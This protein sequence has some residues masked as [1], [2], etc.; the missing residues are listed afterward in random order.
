MRLDETRPVWSRPEVSPQTGHSRSGTG[1]KEV[2]DNSLWLTA[3]T[4]IKGDADRLCPPEWPEL[5]RRRQD[6]KEPA[7]SRP[8]GLPPETPGWVTRKTRSHAATCKKQLSSRTNGSPR[9]SNSNVEL[10]SEAQAFP[11]EVCDETGSMWSF[12]ER[13]DSLKL[14]G[15]ASEN[16]L[17]EKDFR[18]SHLQSTK[19]EN[20]CGRHQRQCRW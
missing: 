2:V 1:S 10:F 17:T 16:N 3:P 18:F 19:M 4:Y 20:G 13:A 15:R 5:P 7:R 12:T 14:P 9:I 8:P 11:Q 6:I